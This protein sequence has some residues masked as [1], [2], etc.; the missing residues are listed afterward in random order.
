MERSHL[1]LVLVLSSAPLAGCI[2]ALNPASAGDGDGIEV[3]LQGHDSFTTE[4]TTIVA[5][6]Q[7]SWG[8]QLSQLW[9]AHHGPDREV[10]DIPAADLD[11]RMAVAHFEP[12]TDDVCQG[13]SIESIERTGETDDGQ[14]V[15]TI[16][17]EVFTVTDPSLECEHS[18]PMQ[19]VTAPAVKGEVH[20]TRTETRLD[21][22]PDGWDGEF[23]EQGSSENATSRETS[24]NTSDG[25]EAGQEVAFE[26]LDEGNDSN[27]TERRDL[28]IRDADAWRGFWANHTE[29]DRPRPAV[30]FDDRMVVAA[31]HGQAPQGCHRVEIERI[32]EAEDGSSLTVHAHERGPN[33]GQMC[34]DEVVHPFHI[35]DL[36]D[37][38]GDVQVEWHEPA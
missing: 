14:P 25:G 6:N 23:T 9:Q 38:E 15:V 3:L 34:T 8:T 24:A 35:V 4:Q 28:V 37:F 26:T 1:L 32:V 29:E 16:E 21:T 33:E 2:E 7:T 22:V 27:V 30:D 31:L 12:R 20:V 5:Y 13:L 10:P 18:A 17:V 19:M 36:D 11:E